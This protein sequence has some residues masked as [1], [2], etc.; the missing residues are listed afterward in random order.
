ME[1]GSIGFCTRDS[2]GLRVR[3]RGVLEFFSGER[4][5]G[6]RARGGS[7][8]LA[9]CAS[10]IFLLRLK[11]SSRDRAK[12]RGDRSAVGFVGCCQLAEG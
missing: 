9:L 5:G 10:T 11:I 3:A 7:P 12:G 1:E 4:V 6:S 8:G 2:P